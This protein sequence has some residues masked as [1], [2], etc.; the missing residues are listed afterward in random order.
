MQTLKINRYE[1]TQ[2]GTFGHIIL[3]SGSEIHSL[4]KPWR[5]NQPNISCVTSGL[6]VAIRH[7]SPRH[8][9]CIALVGGQ[10]SLS[11]SSAARWGILIHPA[12]YERQ[13]EGCI[14]PGLSRHSEMIQRSRDAMD[15]I[16]DE[17]GDA[18][19]VHVAWI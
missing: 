15:L 9:E 17:L 10:A 4:E 18:T 5:D 19:E 11:P 2:A 1:S 3:P 7:I 14:A 16:L 13:L 12:N 6:Y 8:G